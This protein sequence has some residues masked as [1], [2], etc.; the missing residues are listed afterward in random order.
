MEEL[1]EVVGRSIVKF[2]IGFLRVLLFIGWELFFEFVG[3]SIGWAFYRVVSFGRF[4]KVSIGD[5]EK[6]STGTALLVELTGLAVLA[7]LIYLLSQLV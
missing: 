2:V 3:W 7:G 4:P 5:L 6:V 1:V